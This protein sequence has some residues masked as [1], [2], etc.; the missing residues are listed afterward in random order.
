MSTA[1]MPASRSSGAGRKVRHAAAS[2]RATAVLIQ[3]GESRHKG[4]PVAIRVRSKTLKTLAGQLIQMM[5][6]LIDIYGRAVKESQRVGGAVS[7]IVDIGPGG[8]PSFR[9]FDGQAP[10]T[11]KPIAAERADDL[12][13][14]LAAA[15]DRGRVRVA[16]ILRGD[17]MLSAE[18]FAM[19]IGTSRV[20]VNAKRQNK[21]VLGL[22]GAKRGF[23]FPKWQINRDGKPFPELPELFDRL[24]DSPWA[25]YRFL[26]Q[27][28][29]EL[30][31][32]TGRDALSRG[33]SAEVIE[34]AESV[35]RA[36]S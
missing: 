22:D 28:H 5:G 11:A 21:Q 31:G 12:Q 30:D 34:V 29:P 18:E 35:V 3:T 23:R 4:K 13:G 20:T 15:R 19:L 36:A 8:A 2:Q 33:R 16:D 9:P 17:D 10:G 26:V 7:F 14:A 27:H 6:N 32:L 1:K 24:G 25:V